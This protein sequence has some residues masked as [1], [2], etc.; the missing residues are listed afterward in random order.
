MSCWSVCCGRAIFIRICTP[1]LR[2]EQDSQTGGIGKGMKEGRARGI[3]FDVGNG[4]REFFVDGRGATGEGGISAGL[5][6]DRSV[7]RTV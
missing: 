5:D 6:L 3:I 2:G 7:I 4:Q 1:G